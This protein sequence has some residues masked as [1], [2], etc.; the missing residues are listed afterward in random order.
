MLY[1]AVFPFY[2]RVG[3]VIAAVGIVAGP[4]PSAWAVSRDARQASFGPL[5][6]APYAGICI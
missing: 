4:A 1:P 6:M 2:Q 5:L 3:D